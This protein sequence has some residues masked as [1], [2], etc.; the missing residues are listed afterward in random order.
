M[1]VEAALPWAGLGLYVANVLLGIGVQTRAVSTR[2]WRWVHHVLY[3]AVIAGAALAAFGL[4]RLGR[5]WTPLAVTLGALAVLPRLRGGTPA[6]A[7]VGT[8]GLAGYAWALA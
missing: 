4:A 6:H 8:L 5:A 3:A 1:G 7:L 2:R